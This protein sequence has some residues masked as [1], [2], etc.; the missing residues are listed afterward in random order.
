MGFTY[1]TNQPLDHARADYTEALQN[2]GMKPQT[3]RIPAAKASGRVTA[4]A[5]YAHI[6]APHYHACAMDGIALCARVTFGATATTPVDLAAQDFT[7]VD[8]GDPLPESCDAVVMIEDVIERSGGV[9]L[10]SAIAT[11]QNVRQ[12]GE[13]ICAGDMI[14]ASYTKITPAAAGALL[15][16]GVLEVEVLRRPIVGII[17]TGDEIVPPTADPK[18]GEI[19]EFNTTIFGAMLEDWGAVPRPYPIVRDEQTA[20]EDALRRAIAECDVVILNAG[21]SAGREDYAAAAIGQVGRV[22]CH[23]IAMRPGKPA[24]LGMAGAKPVLGVPGYPVSGIVVL[25][26]ILHPLVAALL[27]EGEITAPEAEVLLSQA[28]VSSLKY[29][30]FVRARIGR[31]GDNLIAVPLNKGAG[32]VT[33]FVKADAILDIP[34]DSEGLEAGAKTKAALLRP[35]AEVENTVLITGSHDPLLDELADIAR[36]RWQDFSVSSTH[37]GSMGGIMA[38]RRG[39]AHMAGIHIL[40]EASGTYNTKIVQRYFP[41]GGVT[42][43]ECVQRRQGLMVAPG[44][45][46]H[47]TAIQDLT[48]AGLRY[49][50]RQKGSGTRILC[51]Y[52]CRRAG[53]N[54]ATVYG[55]EREEYT[56][57]AVAALVA[58]GSADAGLGIYAAAKAYGLDFIP[59]CTE[60]Y[61]LLLREESLHTYNIARLINTLS[62]EEFAARLNT[63]GGYTLNRPGARRRLEFL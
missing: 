23:G 37:V 14:L 39:E 52:L 41:L 38:I 48:R 25:E 26:Q 12:I 57:T 44:N 56:H 21:S 5:V 53:V 36:N 4:Q 34:Q 33:S 32:V 19:I 40:D 27:G 11:W 62:T 50:N 2:A 58:A 17:P 28:C 22:F 20:I 15:A 16:G 51:D 47:L 46:L 8:T 55:Y 54:T 42:L 31:V 43:L 10:H 9:T 45:P 29:R 3:E 30:D 35:L 6:C 18:K 60:Q 7:R 63:M 24:V 13:D 61:D 1:L 59:L 49:V